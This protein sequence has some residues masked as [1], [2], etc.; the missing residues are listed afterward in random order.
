[1]TDSVPAP[2]PN[3]VHVQVDASLVFPP[4]A[5][6]V[7]PAPISEAKDLPLGDSVRE[8]LL[9]AEVLPPA[10]TQAQV[11][12]PRRGVFKRIKGIFARVFR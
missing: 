5:E 2:L 9:P 11:H 1:M 3:Q 8:P 4:P 12:K 6:P 10:P 7:A